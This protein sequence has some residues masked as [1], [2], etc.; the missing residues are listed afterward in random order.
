MAD[1]VT[2]YISG[3]PELEAERDAIGQALAGFPINL[4]W[5]IKRTPRFGEPVDLGAVRRSDLFVLLFSSD[6]RAPVGW[7]WIV[8]RQAARP[9]L[10][11]LKESSLQTPAGREFVRD[12]RSEWRP[13]HSGRDLARQLMEAVSTHILERWQQLGLSP[14]E[15]E[16]LSSSLARLKREDSAEEP[17]TAPAGAGDGGVILAPGRDTPRGVVVGD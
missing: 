14:Q 13:F 15:W 2:L 4:G 3:G 5:E 10:A 16:I 7:E 6:I 12:L 1:A 17:E 9:I 11:F 8:A